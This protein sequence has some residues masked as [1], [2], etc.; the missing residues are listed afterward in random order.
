MSSS[1]AGRAAACPGSGPGLQ[2]AAPAGWGWRRGYRAEAGSL[3]KESTIGAWHCQTLKL[4]AGLAPHPSGVA[5]NARGRWWEEMAVTY[6]FFHRTVYPGALVTP[7][8]H[9]AL[10]LRQKPEALHPQGANPPWY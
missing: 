2:S 7:L 3:P 9:T 4:V 10:S 8:S 1:Q 6:F 5:G